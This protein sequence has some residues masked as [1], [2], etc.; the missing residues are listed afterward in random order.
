VLPWTFCFATSVM[1]HQHRR[2]INGRLSFRIVRCGYRR[3]VKGR[4]CTIQ[5]V[6]A[7]ILVIEGFSS[8]EIIFG[9]RSFKT[10]FQ[11]GFH[12]RKI[13]KLLEGSACCHGTYIEE[14][15]SFRGKQATYS[16][17]WRKSGVTSVMKRLCLRN[18]L[19]QRP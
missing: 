3:R 4:I 5:W 6:V 9:L 8:S 11:G 15:H 14:A 17:V 19:K 18:G 13:P 2:K 1:L 10:R 7:H 16:N 12:L